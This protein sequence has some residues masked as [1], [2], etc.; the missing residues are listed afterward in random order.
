MP[1]IEKER[2]FIALA[3]DILQV[4]ILHQGINPR[5]ADKITEQEIQAFVKSGLFKRI[6]VVIYEPVH[7]FQKST[8]AILFDLIRCQDENI[9]Q[10]F[11][12][13]FQ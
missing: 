3:R 7:I 4:G 6:T 5:P 9:T 12:K 10:V 11:I 13:T 2:D 1:W 8:L